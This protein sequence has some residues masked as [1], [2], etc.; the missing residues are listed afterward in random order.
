MSIM[1][2]KPVQA[3]SLGLTAMTVI[4]LVLSAGPGGAY[5]S[6][7]SSAVSGAIGTEPRSTPTPGWRIVTQTSGALDTI[8]APTST[9]AWALGAGAGA[10]NSSTPVG[11]KWNG[12]SWATVN[13]PK[14]VTG[15]IG[16]A[17]ASSP[18]N[19]WAF[20]GASVYGNAASYSGALVLGKSGWVVKKTFLPTGLTSGCSVLSSTNAWVYG[21]TQVAPGVGTWRL[22]RT[23]WT[24]VT[25]GSF[26]LISASEVSASDMWAIAAGKL[27]GVDV[28]A[29]W[30]GSAW[31]SD[32]TFAAAL[33]AQSSTVTWQVFAI[34]AVSAGNV[35]AAGQIGREDSAGNW[36]YS[37]FVLHLSGGKWLRAGPKNPGYYLPGAVSD[38]HGGWW[39]QGNGLSFGA[40]PTAAKLTILHYTGGVWQ[41]TTLSAPKG[42]TMQI[43][44]LV[45]V[46]GSTAMLAV[47]DLYNSQPAL[48][49]A[50]LAFGT[51]P[52]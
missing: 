17:A 25:T 40:G 15:G 9:T 50:V 39:S 42:D 45:H 12:L 8:V 36:S 49:S 47:A 3:I 1:Q 20:A 41:P 23:T 21:L 32:P 33:P 35:W 16:C 6:P 52:K 38:G 30:N 14:S 43:T 5:A 2:R 34:T 4:G 13:F 10:S 37:P 31:S 7:V 51:L 26:S 24:H 19:V 18:S 44:D 27:G 29:H 28:V 11:S 48:R 22:S 46:P